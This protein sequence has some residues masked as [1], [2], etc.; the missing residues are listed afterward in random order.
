[1]A[2]SGECCRLS[3]KKKVCAQGTSESERMNKGA[4]VHEEQ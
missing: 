1:M 3:G 2:V 4:C